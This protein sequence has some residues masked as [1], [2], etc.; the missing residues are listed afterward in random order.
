MF[1]LNN[2]V[3]PIIIGRTGI[4]ELDLNGEIEISDMKFDFNS[5][6]AINNNFNAYLIVDIIYDDREEES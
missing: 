5:I 4:Y 3:E 6:E 2:A 1:Y